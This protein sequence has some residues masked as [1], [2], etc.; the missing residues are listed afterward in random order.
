MATDSGKT[1]S[2][3]RDAKLDELCRL[4]LS[5]ADGRPRDAHKKLRCKYG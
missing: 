2:K 5:R 3:R 1:E 4:A